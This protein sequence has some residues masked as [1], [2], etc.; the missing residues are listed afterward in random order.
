MLAGSPQNVAAGKKYEHVVELIA[1]AFGPIETDQGRR[2]RIMEI[3]DEGD[4]ICNPTGEKHPYL[5]EI[6]ASRLHTQHPPSPM[7]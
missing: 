1:T 4:L 2:A 3:N 7:S 5:A 6:G